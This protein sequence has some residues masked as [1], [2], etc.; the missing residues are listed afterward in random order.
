MKIILF[1][2]FWTI[3]VATAFIT[4]L[5]I[6][7]VITIKDGY[8]GPLF[9][10]LIIEL[11]GA[12]I[13]LFRKADFFGSKIESNVLTEKESQDLKIHHALY[14]KSNSVEENL[15]SRIVDGKVEIPVKNNILG[16]D[17]VPHEHNK[18]LSVAYSYRGKILVKSAMQH[19]VLKL[20]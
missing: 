19:D 5:G 10:A 9:G 11:I 12:V 18:E 15:R 1:F 17:P 7:E 13:S 14:G 2:T 16:G 8:L 6:T 4:L 20:P 3:F